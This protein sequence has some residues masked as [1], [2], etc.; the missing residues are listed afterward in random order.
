MRMSLRPTAVPTLFPM[1][2]VSRAI[3]T[4]KSSAATP[5]R[6]FFQGAT[7]VAQPALA[8]T[9]S[10][11]ATQFLN[12]LQSIPGLQVP[13]SVTVTGSNGGPF[14]VASAL[15][16]A[17]NQLSVGA[18]PAIIS[19]LPGGGSPGAG[20]W[21]PINDIVGLTLNGIVIVNNGYV[22]PGSGA[23]NPDPWVLTGNTVVINNTDQSLTQGISNTTVLYPNLPGLNPGG[24]APVTSVISLGVSPQVTGAGGPIKFISPVVITDVGPAP[25]N[26]TLAQDSLII[27]SSIDLGGNK[28]TVGPLTNST[29]A[30]TGLTNITGAVTN[31]FVA[32]NLNGTNT[33][34]FGG[35]VAPATLTPT[36]GNAANVT[37]IA[38]TYN[39]LGS[40]TDTITGALPG[41]VTFSYNGV[42]G[43]PIGYQS[44]S[45]DLLS[46]SSPG[47]VTFS[48]NGTAA[49]GPL[50]YSALTTA[51][52]VLANL[53]TIPAL[54][55]AGNVAVTGPIGGPFVV[56]FGSALTG[57]SSLTVANG[58]GV[59]ALSVLTNTDLVTFP[60]S[61]VASLAYN[62]NNGIPFSYTAATTTAAQVA[63]YLTSI[64][65]LNTATLSFPVNGGPTILNYNGTP[66]GSFT[67]SSSTTAASIQTLLQAVA[68]LGTNVTVTGATNGG[69]YTVTFTNGASSSLLTLTSGPGSLSYPV[70][71]T[72]AAGG[73]YTV[74]YNSGVTGGTA[75]TVVGGSITPTV[76]PAATTA[77]QIQANL[78]GIAALS[79][80][81]R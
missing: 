9:T 10:T 19:L 68:G 6:Q 24:I 38:L 41:N 27:S 23:V 36:G 45:G 73:P 65:G 71:V 21:N 31:S 33:F 4:C 70:Q 67:N 1:A 54:T 56:T 51:A 55:A 17:T 7:I 39:N 57:G 59:A 28:L 81:A 48:Y 58:S 20:I 18:G 37:N 2:T 74:Y 76:G 5:A 80:P 52:N 62:G 63:A 35:S 42:A 14:T 49:S 12:Y 22:A 53:Q 77:A 61:G 13:G 47:T 44:F 3:L 79:A 78:A 15:F 29:T 75:L 60:A 25:L 46:F 40:A 30:D 32:S 69:P 50:T 26:A 66:V 43:S 8:L 64:G 34:A 16:S 72:G 11:T